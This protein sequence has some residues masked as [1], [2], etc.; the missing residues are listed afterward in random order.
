[1]QSVERLG[2]QPQA[3]RI[4]YDDRCCEAHRLPPETAFGAFGWIRSWVALALGK[5]FAFRK[6]LSYSPVCARNVSNAS[7]TIITAP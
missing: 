6:V 3:R 2:K 7:W 5:R 4:G 1:M